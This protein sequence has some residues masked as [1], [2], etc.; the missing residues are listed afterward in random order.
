MARKFAS[1]LCQQVLKDLFRYYL[2]GL[3]V[4]CSDDVHTL[5]DIVEP[6]TMIIIDMGRTNYI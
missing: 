3:S 1:H 4:P 2:L 6:V 5:V